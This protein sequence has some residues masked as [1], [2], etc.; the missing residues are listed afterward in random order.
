MRFGLKTEKGQRNTNSK[1]GHRDTN[2]KGDR[3]N[4][5]SKGEHNATT[6]GK[7]NDRQTNTK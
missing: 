7:S 5:N 2:S 1:G 3:H 6:Q 4:A